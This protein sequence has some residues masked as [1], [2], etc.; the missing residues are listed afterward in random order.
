VATSHQPVTAGTDRSPGLQFREPSAPPHPIPVLLIDACRSSRAD[1]RAELERGGFVI[2]ADVASMHGA[3]T[4]LRSMSPAVV[5]LDPDLP[6]MSAVEACRRVVAAAEDAVVVVV[7]RRADALSVRAALDTGIRGYVVR[8]PDVEATVGSAIV[9]A[10]AG[11]T[12]I[13]DRVAETLQRAGADTRTARPELTA[14]ERD[15]LGLVAEGLTNGE[16]GRRLYLSPHTVKDYL[17]AAMRKLGVSTRGAAALVANER[18]LIARPPDAAAVAKP[19]DVE[20]ERR[21]VGASAGLADSDL[22]IPAVK[23][24]PG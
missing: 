1:L 13:D 6:G 16:I 5:V 7:A 15:V 23:I 21:S 8:S 14:R 11:E 10:A 12:V 20:V 19:G 18:G 17:S 3:E 22:S 24:R 4:A 9:R 2:L